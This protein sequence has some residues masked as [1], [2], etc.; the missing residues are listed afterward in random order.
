VGT[1]VTF[2][3]FAAARAAAGTAEV[4]LPGG[5][6]QQVLERLAADLPPRFGAVLAVS[7]LVADGRRLD[8]TSAE[9]LAGG[10]VIDVLPPF[11]GG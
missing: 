9:L 1:G 4:Q 3:L 5:P 2:R 8:P 10:T 6:T 7:S 11:A